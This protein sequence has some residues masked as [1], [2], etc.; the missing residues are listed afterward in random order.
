MDEIQYSRFTPITSLPYS[1]GPPSATAVIRSQPEDF[2]VDEVLGFQPAGEGE[3]MLL[4]L[5]KRNTN[6]DWLAQ[7]LAKLVGVS[8][9]DVGYAGLKDRNAVTSQWFSVRVPSGIKPDWSQLESDEVQV[10]DMVKHRRKLRRGVLKQ[11]RFSLHLRELNGD[12]S[13]IEFRLER[14]AKQGVPN[15][16]GEQRFGH[17]QNNLEMADRLFSGKLNKISRHKRGIYLSAARSSL[18]NLVLATRVEQG[19]WNQ[20][21]PGDLMQLDGSN[22]H[23]PVTQIDAEIARRIEEMDIYP[24]GPL[25]G[26]GQQQV[27]DMAAELENTVLNAYP[28]WLTGLIKFGLHHDRRSLLTRVYELDWSWTADSDLELGFGLPSGS[29]ATMVLR[30]I[31]LMI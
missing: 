7:Q 13:E 5:R 25:W 27:S 10:L 14:V 2:R 8:G 30:E 17:G 23:F 18:F 21:M 24:T 11:N 26:K 28:E 19:S 16:F 22:S 29:Y 31:S 12:R 4:R 6:T 3:H 9:R 1:L 15:Y 20:A